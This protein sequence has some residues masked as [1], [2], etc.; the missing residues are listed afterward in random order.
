MIVAGDKQSQGGAELVGVS[1]EA[2]AFAVESGHIATQVGIRAFDGVG[3]L[4]ARCHIVTCPAFTLTVDQ[5]LVS[6]KSIAV[7][8]MHLG[9][10]RKHPVHQR[11]HGFQGAFFDHIPSED[12]SCFAVDNGGYIEE[13]GRMLFVFFSPVVLFFWA[14]LA[15]QKV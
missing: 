3:L 7:E 15:L 4:F 1:R 10:Q 11:L 8:L 14:R 5:L 9:H 2:A 13:T 6:G 12:T